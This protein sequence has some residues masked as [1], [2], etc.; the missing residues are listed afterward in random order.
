MADYNRQNFSSMKNEAVRNAR[1]MHR[2]TADSPENQKSDNIR[3]DDSNT[4][5]AQNF[6]Q[7]VNGNSGGI[8]RIAD[9]FFENIGISKGKLDSD[10]I[11]VILMIIMLAREGADLKLLLALG[12]IIM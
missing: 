5:S 10:K 11:I 6:Q 4:S 2:R 8:L 12:Y 7:S 3:T 1:E 9:S